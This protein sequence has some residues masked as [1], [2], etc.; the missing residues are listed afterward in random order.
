MSKLG[1]GDLFKLGAAV[2]KVAY[3]DSQVKKNAETA[4]YREELQN[5]IIKLDKLSDIELLYDF[6]EKYDDQAGRG[7][8]IF[9]S[10]NRMNTMFMA[11]MEVFKKRNIQPKEVKCRECN[12]RLGYRMVPLEF[13]RIKGEY[14]LTNGYCECR[15]GKSRRWEI[16]EKY[17]GESYINVYEY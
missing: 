4:E 14:G 17:G 3:E 12:R 9:N 13:K 16:C 8:F 7:L 1:F 6:H 2:G 5:K 10:S 15:C 11:Y